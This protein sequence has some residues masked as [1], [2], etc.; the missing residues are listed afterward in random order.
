MMFF[1]MFKD[2]PLLPSPGQ[3]NLLALGTLP[4]RLD[5]HAVDDADHRKADH[6]LVEDAQ[7][8][9]PLLGQDAPGSWEFTSHKELTSQRP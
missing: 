5:E 3:L 2:Q 7:Q 9:E 4:S 1:N 6:Q 8:H